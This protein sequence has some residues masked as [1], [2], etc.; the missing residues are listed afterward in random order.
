MQKVHS[1]SLSC[2]TIATE[3]EFAAIGYNPF[4]KDMTN[5]PTLEERLAAITSTKSGKKRD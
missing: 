5:L 4:E 1:E 2:P 3:E